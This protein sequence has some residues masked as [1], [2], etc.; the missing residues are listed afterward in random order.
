M[1]TG[2]TARP[3]QPGEAVL[4][5]AKRAALGT[6]NVTVTVLTKSFNSITLLF[7]GAINWVSPNLGGWL[8]ATYY[9]LRCS[10]QE[11][12][13]EHKIA[14]LTEANASLKA[15]NQNLTEQRDHAVAKASVLQGEKDDLVV[16]NRFLDES[17]TQLALQCQD[18]QTRNGFAERDVQALLG[19]IHLMNIQFANLEKQKGEA[20]A[21]CKIL[22]AQ[23]EALTPLAEAKI[24]SL[25]HAPNPPAKLPPLNREEV[26]NRLTVEERTKIMN[27]FSWRVV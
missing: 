23:I 22:E 17:K 2:V 16:E 18:L 19:R 24:T 4:A 9:S 1:A 11:Y 25:A 21:H 26:M 14:N 20:V 6:W 3:I 15:Q 13:N 10:W 27:L 5:T 7:W 12:W 8:T